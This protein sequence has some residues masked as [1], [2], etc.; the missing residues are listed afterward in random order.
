[1]IKVVYI[2]GYNRSGSTLLDR[3]LGQVEG[4]V[5]VGE[6]RQIWARGLAQDQA[7][8]CGVPFQRC[9]FWRAV[10]Q[11]AYGPLDPDRVARMLRLARSV[12]CIR[13]VPQLAWPRLR[14]AAYARRFQEFA[15]ALEQLYGSIHQVGGGRIIVDSSKSP[16]YCL[17]LAQMPFLEL[18]IVH[19][20]RDS[21]AVAYSQ[22]RPKRKPEIYWADQRMKVMGPSRTAF[23]WVLT[24]ALLH[25][26]E[27]HPH[28]L[29]VKY[30]DFASNPRETVIRIAAASGHYP[31]TLPFLKERS[32]WLG[33]AHTVSGN[34]IRFE[35][36][37][38]KVAPDLEWQDKLDKA[39]RRLVSAVTAPL[40]LKYGYL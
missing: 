27:R 6:V 12:A 35:Q 40:L 22:Q 36:G 33:E 16:S 3:M 37:W 14:T 4:Y 21:R 24:N 25:L 10:L 30:E 28:Y 2:A 32:V 38:M 29:R 19:L 9:Q 11:Q 8:G 23:T 39:H 17:L 26:L 13:T 34:P 1:L 15:G 18:Y 31:D 5:S 7:C 20:V